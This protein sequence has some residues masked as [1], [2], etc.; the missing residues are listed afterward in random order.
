MTPLTEPTGHAAAP[1][2]TAAPARAERPRAHEFLV[3]ELASPAAARRRAQSE[4]VGRITRRIAE[5]ENVDANDPAIAL[6]AL[7]VL[8]FGEACLVARDGDERRADAIVREMVDQLVGGNLW[9][10]E[11]DELHAACRLLIHR[12][13]ARADTAAWAEAWEQV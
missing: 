11:I 4:S 2:G 10:D 1:A 13:A 6:L 3:P 7:T 12:N 9:L 8:R 5:R